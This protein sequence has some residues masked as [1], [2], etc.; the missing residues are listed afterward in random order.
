MKKSPSIY[1]VTP[2][3]NSKA[4]TLRFVKSLKKQSYK[5]FKLIVVDDGSDG[6]LDVLKADYPEVDVLKGTGDLWWSGGTNLGVK[7]AL[8]HKADY[9]LTINHDVTL[10]P[11]YLSSLVACASLH[12]KALIGSMVVNREQPEFVWF[13]GGG[14]SLRQGLNQHTTGHIGD[15]TA[16]VKSTWL[17]GMG[18]LIPA[19]TFRKIGF[20]DEKNFPLYFG[21][22]DFSERAR[23]AGYELWVDPRSVVYGDIYDNWVGRNVRYPKLIFLYDLFTIQ[24]SPF[25]WKSRRLFYKKYWPGNYRL[26]LLIF[27]T[28]GS[29]SV[30]YGYIV[31]L[32]NRII[33]PG[34]MQA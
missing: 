5:N 26:A 2:I 6:T 24:N 29:A 19:E 7:R 12:P 17:T 33:R 16:P 32:I 1:I 30:Y 13:F 21:D 15:F 18:V 28:V 25:Q 11:N 4:V 23:R 27:Y 34:R 22:A 8:K 31:G 20:F 3:F 10:K 14:Y 9:I